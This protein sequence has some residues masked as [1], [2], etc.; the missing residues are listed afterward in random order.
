M[1]PVFKR[2]ILVA[3]LFLGSAYCLLGVMAVAHLSSAGDPTVERRAYT[4]LAGSVV[5]GA[6]G[7]WQLIVLMRKHGREN[8]I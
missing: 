3:L 1:R 4:W 5:L 7:L 6:L 8:L 2:V